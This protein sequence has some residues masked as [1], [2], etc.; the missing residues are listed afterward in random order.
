[1][2]LVLSTPWLMEQLQKAIQ[3]SYRASVLKEHKAKSLSFAC[4]TGKRVSTI[5]T[6]HCFGTYDIHVTL[7]NNQEYAA[8][9]KSLDKLMPK[10]KD[11]FES[12]RYAEAPFDNA[13]C[14]AYSFKRNVD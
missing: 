8:F 10:L 3:F 5:K 1:M 7:A 12:I 9:I 2:S 14:I 13:I 6:Y 4:W 11:L